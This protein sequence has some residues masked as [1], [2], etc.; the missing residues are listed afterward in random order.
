MELVFP[1]RPPLIRSKLCPF[2]IL[3]TWVVAIVLSFPAFYTYKSIEY[4]Y[5]GKA[6]CYRIWKDFY[7]RNTY[8][9]AI[10]FAFA[11]I[12]FVLII[13]LYSII[14]FN[15]KSQKIP[16]EPSNN[17]EDQRVRRQRKVVKMAVAIVLGFALCWGPLSVFTILNVLVWNN[18]TGFFCSII[19]P[20]YVVVFMSQAN[21]ALNPCICFTFSGNYRQGLKDLLGCHGIL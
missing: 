20:W 6:K 3:G 15:L 16:G 11:A 21:G 1:L 2:F 17:A 12:S 9:Y 13:I 10:I 14:I 19:T 18:T 7:F 8:S 4:N 5:A